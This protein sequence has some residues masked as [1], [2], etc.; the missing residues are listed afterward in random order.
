MI[1]SCGHDEQPD[2]RRVDKHAETEAEA[3]IFT[4]TFVDNKNA[5]NT[6]VMISGRN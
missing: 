2:D 3:G 5:A 4:V 1:R 6:L